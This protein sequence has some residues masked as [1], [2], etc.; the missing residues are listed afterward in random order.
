M[1]SDFDHKK[2]NADLYQNDFVFGSF[3]AIVNMFLVIH[4]KTKPVWNI[5]SW[6]K[7]IHLKVLK[8]FYSRIFTKNFM[9]S[10]FFS[11]SIP[12]QTWLI[13]FSGILLWSKEFT[14]KLVK[15]SEIPLKEHPNLKIIS[16]ASIWSHF[17]HQ[18]FLFDCDWNWNIWKNEQI[19]CAMIMLTKIR[20]KE[21]KNMMASKSER[22]NNFSLW[23]TTAQHST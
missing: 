11:I 3:L 8:I 10:I 22:L 4:L 13:L 14:S 7:R 9:F 2:W 17:I 1:E 15:L 20:I 23:R 16:M 12:C 18:H 5:C 19:Q 21:M 6:A